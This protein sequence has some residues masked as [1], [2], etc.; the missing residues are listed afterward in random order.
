VTP[1]SGSECFGAYYQAIM[2][3]KPS[4]YFRLSDAKPGALCRNEVSTVAYRCRYAATGI[5]ATAGLASCEQGARLGT[6]GSVGL[7]NAMGSLA[8][9]GDTP[10]TLE[11][12][13][14]VDALPDGGGLPIG[15][16]LG[17]AMLTQSYAPFAGYDIFIGDESAPTFFGPREEMWVD[18][19]LAL[20]AQTGA[21]PQPNQY[22][23]LVL[24]HGSSNDAGP[25]DDLLYQ[26][27]DPGVGDILGSSERP[28]TMLAFSWEGYLGSVAE[29][30]IYDRALPTIEIQAHYAAAMSP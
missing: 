12:W 6:G 20:F 27:G 9:A 11:A 30:A 21:F 19:G 25:H 3:S 17:S 13:L 8:F 26:N 4:A 2:S 16:T 28:E 24:T 15:S 1:D 5:V 23:H 18:G 22:F 7:E 29:V 14:E 10:F